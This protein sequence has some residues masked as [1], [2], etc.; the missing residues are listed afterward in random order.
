MTVSNIKINDKKTTLKKKIKK[1]KEKI[2]EDEKLNKKENEYYFN[3]YKH[4]MKELIIK[5]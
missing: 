1:I 5:I 3:A 4:I 2:D